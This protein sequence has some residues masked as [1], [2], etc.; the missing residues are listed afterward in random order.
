M[1]NFKKNTRL[2][3]KSRKMCE[4][5][6]L[7]GQNGQEENIIRKCDE[8]STAKFIKD[9]VFCQFQAKFCMKILQI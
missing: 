5:S 9:A 2:P 8:T 4:M 7:T 1:K 6:L 3:E